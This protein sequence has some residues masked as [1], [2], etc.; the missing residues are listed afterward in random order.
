[1]QVAVFD[2]EVGGM[3]GDSFGPLPKMRALP[4]L[5]HS[6]THTE[7]LCGT[8]LSTVFRGGSF[9]WLELDKNGRSRDSRVSGWRRRLASLQCGSIIGKN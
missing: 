7:L 9:S 3:N 1:M 4:T 6:H 5:T 2:R 8:E